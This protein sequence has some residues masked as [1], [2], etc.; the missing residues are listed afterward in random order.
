MN[1][2]NTK[3]AA[4]FESLGLTKEKPKLEEK[5]LGQD[6]FLSL[7]SAQMKNQ[8]PFKPME[9]GEF[10]SQM[11]QFSAAT[12]MKE[13]KD[14]FKTL[15]G[16]LQS[17]QALQASSMVGR[18]VLVPGNSV[19]LGQAGEL[20]GAVDVPVSTPELNI[21]IIDNNGQLVKK[22]SLGNRPEGSVQFKW[23]GMTESKPDGNGGYLEPVRAAEGRYRI[24]AEALVEGKP[25]AVK[26]YVSDNVSSVS[27]GKPGEGVT[28]NLE[29]AGKTRLAEV[30]EIM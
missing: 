1:P 11:A 25:Q 13:I 19:S 12:G 29:Q 26:T 24:Q 17:T 21:N 10:I 14:A 22:I 8:D 18:K 4:S 3:D 5:K 30:K 15:A 28:L 9:N 6:D 23:D 20:K 27:L 7:M 2:V 16:S